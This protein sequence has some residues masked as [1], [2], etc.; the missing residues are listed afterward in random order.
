[1]AL[2]REH[3]A[4]HIKLKAS[5]GIR[6]LEDAQAFLD[7]GADRLGASALVGEARKG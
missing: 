3:L 4:D 7:L 2:L 5:G 6:T 1:V